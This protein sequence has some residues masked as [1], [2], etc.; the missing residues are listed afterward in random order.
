MSFLSVVLPAACP[1]NSPAAEKSRRYGSVASLATRTPVRHPRCVAERPRADRRA[2]AWAAVVLAPVDA[3][4]CGRA[5]EAS[6]HQSRR[7]FERRAHLVVR[8][9]G[10]REPRRDARLEE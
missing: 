6:V 10:E 3:V 5:G 7:G 8:R 2:A 9:L 4:T 1:P